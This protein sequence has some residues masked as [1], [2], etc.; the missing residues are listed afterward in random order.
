MV[1]SD[2][3]LFVA[4]RARFSAICF[5]TKMAK[6]VIFTLMRKLIVRK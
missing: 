2:T 6:T 5:H 3:I 1:H 4:V